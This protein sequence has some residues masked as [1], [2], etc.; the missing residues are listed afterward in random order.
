M[1]SFKLSDVPFCFLTIFFLPGETAFSSPFRATI[2]KENGASILLSLPAWQTALTASRVEEKGGGGSLI[3][4]KALSLFLPLTMLSVFLV[5][6][7]LNALNWQSDFEKD[8]LHMY[9]LAAR[10]RLLYVGKEALR[11]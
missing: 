1:S 6:E 2:K 3:D 8:V 10:S 11:T 7:F 4:L 9:L 5:L